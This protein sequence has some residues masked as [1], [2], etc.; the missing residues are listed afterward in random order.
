MRALGV[1]WLFFGGIAACAAPREGPVGAKPGEMTSHVEKSFVAGPKLLPAGELLSWLE[2]KKDAALLRVPV[3]I[4]RGEIGAPASA[5]LGELEVRLDDAALGISLEDR[6]SAACPGRA[7]CRVW[8]EGRY[9][10]HGELRIHHFARAVRLD[11][12][13]DFV[14]VER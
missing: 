3:T 4:T 9:H 11:E 12:A 10:G 5:K 7:P 6:V 1:W 14:E 2:S 13:A 8:L